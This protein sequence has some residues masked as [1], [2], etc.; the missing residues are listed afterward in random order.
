M[1]EDEK[2]QLKQKEILRILTVS[3]PQGGRLVLVDVFNVVVRHQEPVQSYSSASILL[4]PV[5][6][7]FP[8]PFH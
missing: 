5:Y 3:M 7:L 2:L 4:L 6:L 8:V 1:L